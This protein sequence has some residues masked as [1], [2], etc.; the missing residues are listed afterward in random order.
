MIQGHDD[1]EDEKNRRW[2]IIDYTEHL[3]LQIFV[4]ETW[5]NEHAE[6]VRGKRR[7]F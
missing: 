4:W 1:L 7:R 3:Y 2:K 5:S 6:K